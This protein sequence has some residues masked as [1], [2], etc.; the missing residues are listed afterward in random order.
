MEGVQERFLQ[1]LA[2]MT[3]LE[4][5]AVLFGLLS[6]WYS[7]NRNILVFPTGIINTAIFVYICL[8]AKLYADM[9]INVYYTVMSVYGWY[10]WTRKVDRQELPVSYNSGRENLFSILFFLSSFGFWY[11]ILTQYTDSDVP[12]WDSLTTAIFI[13]AMWLMAKKRVENWW[14]WIIGDLVSVPLYFYKGLVLS[15]FQFLVFTGLAVAGLIAWRN[16]VKRQNAMTG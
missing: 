6:V 11:L 13:V 7:K 4:A 15:S 8:V 1:G 5:F 3:W 16:D 12:V 9:A 14:A 10:V 2:Q